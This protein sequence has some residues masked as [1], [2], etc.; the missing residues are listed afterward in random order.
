MASRLAQGQVPEEGDH[1]QRNPRFA[2]LIV[3]LPDESSRSL[4][5]GILNCASQQQGDEE[6]GYPGPHEKTGSVGGG[7]LKGSGSIS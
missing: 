6:D 5:P 2:F 3:C 1:L 7:L 4:G